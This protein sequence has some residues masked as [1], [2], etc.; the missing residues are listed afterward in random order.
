MVVLFKAEL[1]TP[2]LSADTR[3]YVRQIPVDGRKILMSFFEDAALE[4]DSK[5]DVKI[6]KPLTDIDLTSNVVS[7]D[8]ISVCKS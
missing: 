4:L 8:K 3:I 6:F 2:I 1:H 5:N 7:A